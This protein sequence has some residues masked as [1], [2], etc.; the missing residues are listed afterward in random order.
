MPF[1]YTFPITFDIEQQVSRRAQSDIE[2]KLYDRDLTTPVLV[3][4]LTEKVQGLE[5]STRLPGGFH[6]CSFKLKADLP[7]AWTWI[8]Q[9]AFY[10]IVITDGKKTLFEGRLEDIELGAGNAGA[11]AY[12]YFANL[13][14][15]PYRTAYNAVASVVIKAVL[16]AACTQISAD[17]THIDATDVTI[18]SGADASYLDIYPNQIVDKLTAFSDSTKGQWDFAIWEDRIAYLTKRAVSSVNW[19]VNLGDLA[20]FKLKHRAGDMWNSVYAVYD[21]GGLARTA[22][23][24]DTA[25]QAKYGLTRQY[26][27]PNLGTVAAAAAQGNRDGWLESHK[28]IWPKLEDITLGPTVFDSNGVP[29]PS[30][31]V[32]AG[33]VI[34]I[35][36][37][38]PATGQLD[39]VT[40]DALRTFFIVETNYNADTGENSLVVETESADLDAILARSLEGV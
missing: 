17:Q 14:D 5:F 2:V 11:T 1:P 26:V 3:D 27:V 16:T 28:D 40:R 20:S 13:T 6:I 25:S 24:D 23:A 18:T 10:R 29:F 31:W 34:R 15:Y 37:L 9:Y 4:N 22:D 7:K 32:R 33:E 35:K 30:S 19:G 8:S 39:T 21:A 36:D 12:G 38:V